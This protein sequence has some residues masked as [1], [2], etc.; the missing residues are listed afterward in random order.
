MEDS[1]KKSARVSRNP[2]GHVAI[3]KKK[4]Q[5]IT[6]D[7]QLLVEAAGIEPAVNTLRAL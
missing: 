2:H 3:G 1:K 7:L 5:Q 4:G 6:V